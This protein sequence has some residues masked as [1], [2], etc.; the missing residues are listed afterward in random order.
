MGSFQSLGKLG[1][2]T[3]N[4]LRGAAMMKE[5]GVV[6]CLCVLER[7][8]ATR[9]RREVSLITERVQEEKESENIVKRYV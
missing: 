6:D 7:K 3:I 2:L 9:R 5:G 8:E 4:T 1:G